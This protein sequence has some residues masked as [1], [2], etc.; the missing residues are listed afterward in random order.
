MSTIHY[1]AEWA[2]GIACGVRLSDRTRS[3]HN[4]SRVSCVRC[5]LALAKPGTQT[6]TRRHALEVLTEAV[7][8]AI[9]EYDRLGDH[10][11]AWPGE[12]ESSADCVRCAL[13]RA[14]RGE[15]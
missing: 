10:T 11:L 8:A 1:E 15:S 4:V 7:R 5:K 2:A 3:T 12:H 6:A 9:R 13:K 14:L